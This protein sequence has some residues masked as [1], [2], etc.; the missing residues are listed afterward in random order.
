MSTLQHRRRRQLGTPIRRMRAAWSTVTT[1]RPRR[2]AVDALAAAGH[3]S[4]AP[5]AQPQ[6]DRYGERPSSW[7]RTPGVGR[8]H[9][10]LH[11]VPTAPTPE[12]ATH[13]PNAL[14]PVLRLRRGRPPTRHGPSVARVRLGVRVEAVP[15][16]RWPRVA[17][18]PRGSGVEGRFPTAICSPVV[19]RQPGVTVAIRIRVLIDDGPGAGCWRDPLIDLPSPPIDRLPAWWPSPHRMWRAGE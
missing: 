4:N 5:S 10:G 13:Y 15:F 3:D 11:A 8:R 7:R 9:A 19:L 17:A 16:L 18:R 6:A 12:G 14:P 2:A 1:L